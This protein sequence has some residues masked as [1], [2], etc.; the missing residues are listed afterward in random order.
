MNANG[1]FEAFDNS[2]PYKMT[3][4]PNPGKGMIHGTGTDW[5]AP[6]GTPIPK[7]G[8]KVVMSPLESIE[9]GNGFL[10]EETGGELEMNLN[11]QTIINAFN[12][13]KS[14]VTAK[15][16]PLKGINIL[17]EN[18]DEKEFE[19][20]ATEKANEGTTKKPIEH[21]FE[22]ML[23]NSAGWLVDEFEQEIPFPTIENAKEAA[24]QLFEDFED[25]A[26]IKICEIVKCN[27]IDDIIDREYLFPGFDKKKIG[28]EREKGFLQRASDLSMPD[29]LAVLDYVS[30]MAEGKE[31]ETEGVIAEIADK[32]TMT[33]F[34]EIGQKLLKFSENE[35]PD[36]DCEDAAE[37]EPAKLKGKFI[38][39]RIKKAENIS[40]RI[41]ETPINPDDEY[42]IGFHYGF[43]YALEYIQDES[44]TK[45][46]ILKRSVEEF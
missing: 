2:N 36:A 5:A 43:R 27:E 29:F 34:F 18:Y 25:L 45:K 13:P 26:F 4:R 46:Q 19:E 16:D 24:S 1:P 22:L 10:P 17:I 15:R 12:S 23:Y 40:R 8:G 32:I 20:W 21:R 11:L 14:I 31:V 9:I 41:G 28:T 39:K 33:D 3:K 35:E 6:A 42:A 44:I 38:R 7:E 37:E 30:A